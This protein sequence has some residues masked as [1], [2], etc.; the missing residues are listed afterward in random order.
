MLLRNRDFLFLLALVLGIVFPQGAQPL[1][2]L[3]LPALGAVMTLAVLGMPARFAPDRGGLARP[4]ASGVLLSY[5]LLSGLFLVA[6]RLV[7]S[8]SYLQN[9]FLALALAP[10]GIAVIP[11]TEFYGGDRLFSLVG[12]VAAHLG[13][14]ALAPLIALVFVG[15]DVARP[16]TVAIVLAELVLL[17]WVAGRTLARTRWAARIEP[18]RGRLTNWGFFLVIYATTGANGDLLLADPGAIAISALVG[19]ASTFGLALLVGG[20]CGRLGIGARTTASAVLLGTLKNYGVAAGIALGFFGKKEAVPAVVCGAV[21][22]LYS[23]W[24]GRGNRT[25]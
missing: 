12:T 19:V 23:V 24:L 7:P 21:M 18:W 16:T 17:P 11:F 15:A 6:S 4:A 8:G 25:A 3:L 14:L 1:L 20:V 9:G 2:P 13:G 22:I 5:G 10:P